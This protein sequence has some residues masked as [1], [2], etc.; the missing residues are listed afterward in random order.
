MTFEKLL[1][2]TDGLNRRFPKGNDPFQ[3][4]TRL[5]EESGEL[6]QMI[7]HFEGSGVK[8]EKYGAP[9]KVKLAKEVMDVLRCGLQVAIYYSIGEELEAR[10]NDSYE[11]M[12]AEGFIEEIVTRKESGVG[13]NQ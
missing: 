10:I 6:A 7:N 3:I 9:D 5:L 12:K 1:V 2:I 11:K 13:S 4:M 8:L